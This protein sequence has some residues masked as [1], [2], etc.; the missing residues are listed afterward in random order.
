MR[1]P[2]NTAPIRRFRAL[3]TCVAGAAALFVLGAC[4]E[5]FDRSSLLKGYR[6]VALETSTPTAAPDGEVNLT[7]VDHDTEPGRA[8]TYTF[9]VCPYSFGANVAYACLLPETELKLPASSDGTLALNL[10]TAQFGPH[11][12]ITAALRPVAAELAKQAAAFT[13]TPPPI[14]AEVLLAIGIDL[15]VKVES[16]PEG[17]RQTSV[18]SIL[19]RFPQEQRCALSAPIGGIDPATLM[20]AQDLRGEDRDDATRAAKESNERYLATAQCCSPD[21]ISPG[22]KSFVIEGLDADGAAMADSKVTLKVVPEDDARQNFWLD[23]I[24]QVCPNS[25]GDVVVRGGPCREE[26]YYRWYVTGGD[27]D[28]GVGVETD[29]LSLRESE[30]TTPEE[31]GPAKVYLVAFDGR[32]GTTS[33]VID[34]LIKAP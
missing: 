5:E 32:G 7:A 16:G 13:D 19:V 3:W 33:R 31:P 8:A 29:T 24:E 15:W 1:A 26:L 20:C 18:R 9:T 17:A 14:T 27:L 23:N 2:R 6:L 34:V 21:N 30:W 10:A 11:T 4:G 28:P 22:I 25:N 12:G